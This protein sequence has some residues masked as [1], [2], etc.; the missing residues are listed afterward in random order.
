MAEDRQREQREGRERSRRTLRRTRQ[1]WPM[2]A[3]AL[4]PI[5]PFSALAFLIFDATLATFCTAGVFVAAVLVAEHLAQSRWFDGHGRAC[6]K[7]VKLHGQ[8]DEVVERSSNFLVC[9][10]AFEK[11]LFV[12]DQ[13]SAENLQF[14]SY[15]NGLQKRGQST[16]KPTHVPHW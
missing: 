15:R 3:I 2:M 5:A 7:I 11:A 13:V 6:V 4:A 8:H 16:H 12:A 9:Q 1:A 14:S 10:A